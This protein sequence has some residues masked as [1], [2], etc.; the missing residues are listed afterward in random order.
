MSEHQPLNNIFSKLKH[1]RLKE[2]P[3]SR[4]SSSLAEFILKVVLKVS[5]KFYDSL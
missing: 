3:N 2:I 1:F 4:N 5:Y